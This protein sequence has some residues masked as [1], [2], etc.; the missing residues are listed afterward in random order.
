MNPNVPDEILKKVATKKNGK[1]G[2]VFYYS[3][4]IMLFAFSWYALHLSI[5]AN[6]LSIKKL[7]AEG[8]E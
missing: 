7:K 2:K 3:I 1:V 6:K 5:K 8:Y 4:G